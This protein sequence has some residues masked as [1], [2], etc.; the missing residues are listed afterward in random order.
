MPVLGLPNGLCAGTD[1]NT[2]I[3]L[4]NS[5]L[6]KAPGLRSTSLPTQ[7]WQ[8]GIWLLDSED[9]LDNLD[10]NRLDIGAV[11]HLRVGHDRRRIGVDQHNL[12]SLL[13]QRLARL[14]SRVVELARL[15][16]DDRARTNDQNL[17]NVSTLGHFGSAS[18][19]LWHHLLLTQAERTGRR[20]GRA[21]LNEFIQGGG[22][23]RRN[24]PI[25]APYGEFR[26]G[27]RDIP[28]TESTSTLFIWFC[29]AHL[30]HSVVTAKTSGTRH[31]LDSAPDSK[32]AASGRS[33]P[34]CHVGNLRFR[35]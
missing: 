30:R 27:H 18:R 29:S 26:Q 31:I 24:F 11:S 9:L 19:Q 7:G 4:E 12:I 6:M 13:P 14:G 34:N 10:S 35:F 16:N 15:A 5:C 17:V 20:S 21:R 3:P 22:A 8:Y 25:L 28:C 2:T 1:Q 32:K 23:A 33:E